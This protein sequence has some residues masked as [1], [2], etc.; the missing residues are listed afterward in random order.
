MK[1]RSKAIEQLVTDRLFGK[2]S[3]TQGQGDIC[4]SLLSVNTALE[5]LEGVIEAR[6]PHETDAK[7]FAKVA[8]FATKLAAKK[9]QVSAE[10]ERFAEHERSRLQAEIH[11]KS[12]LEPTKHAGEIRTVLRSLPHL[13]RLKLLQAAADGGDTATLAAV[14]E[15]NAVMTGI[16]DDI[17]HRFQAQH[18]EQ[19]AGELVRDLTALDDLMAGVPAVMSLL[20]QA[21]DTSH[22]PVF[23]KE[24]EEAAL[25]ANNAAAKFQSALTQAA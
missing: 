12:K 11:E 23:V 17:R 3:R 21:I 5:A 7:H 14:F 22:D 9:E 20:D 2:I 16:E 18:Q 13:E 24:A 19:T 6:D 10:I 8:G 1:K 4:R 25:R 15:G